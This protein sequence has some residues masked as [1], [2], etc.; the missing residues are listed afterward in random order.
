MVDFDVNIL[1]EMGELGLL[2]ATINGYGCA[3]VSF[4][5]P[6]HSV[7]AHTRLGVIGR[8]RPHCA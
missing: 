6:H 2:G 5:L 3:G 1:K 7:N 8:V 4:G